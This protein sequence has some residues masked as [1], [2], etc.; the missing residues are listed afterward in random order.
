MINTMQKTY[1][2]YCDES[3]HI[4]HDHQ[5][6]MLIGYVSSP[7]HMVHKHSKNIGEIK[8]RHNFYAEIKWTKVSKSKMDFYLEL[9]D[10]F[11]ESE[12]MFRAIVI[13]KSELRNEEYG[14]THDDFYYKMYYHLLYHKL[15]MLNTYNVY[16]DIKDTL[17]AQK[18]KKL[19]EILNVRYEVIRNLQNIRS[20]ES[21]LL[22]LADFL[23]GALSYRLRGAESVEAK[24]RII[25]RIE[26]CSGNNLTES[27]PKAHDKFNLFF[28]NLK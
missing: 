21:V 28:I 10:Y 1:N 27:T 16:L 11:F 15:D 14:Q 5:P 7:I 17:S 22:Q 9:V 12:L 6:F 4:E 25:E 13:D 26:K 23:M 18:V 20:N 2:L 19:R 8:K 3:C 24:N